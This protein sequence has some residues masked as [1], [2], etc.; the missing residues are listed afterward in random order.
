MRHS[1]HASEAAPALANAPH[2]TA[3]MIP[4]TGRTDRRRHA[5]R[6]LGERARGR[7][8]A[9]GVRLGLWLGLGVSGRSRLVGVG[10]EEHAVVGGGYLERVRLVQQVLGALDRQAPPHLRA[11]RRAPQP[12]RRCDEEPRRQAAAAAAGRPSR[13][14]PPGRNGIFACAT[15]GK[16][17]FPT[18][19]SGATTWV[20]QKRNTARSA[21]K[22][23][24]GARWCP[25][26]G[27]R[28]G[29]RE[30]ARDGAPQ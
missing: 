15:Q 23:M 11:G 4:R 29:C 25:K 10:D 12:A 21:P 30:A 24:T 28:G 5:P 3:G 17:R 13:Q 14:Q 16:A 8:G 2:N 19:L 7:R 27:G 26:R 18:L 9:A 20:R 6:P 22:S 1:P